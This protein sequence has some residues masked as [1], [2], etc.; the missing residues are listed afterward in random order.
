MVTFLLST[1]SPR[2][3]SSSRRR[4]CKEYGAKKLTSFAQQRP[5]L[6]RRRRRRL[7]QSPRLV[8]LSVARDELCESLWLCQY[9]RLFLF[10]FSLNPPLG[11][12][13]AYLVELCVFHVGQMLLDEQTGLNSRRRR[14][15]LLGCS[16]VWENNLA[17]LLQ[18]LLLRG[19]QAVTEYLGILT[20]PPRGRKRQ[21]VMERGTERL[22]SVYP[23]S[24]SI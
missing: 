4:R 9:C 8:A 19:G 14:G 21:Y 5:G 1:N 10:F 3:V 11:N 6:S 20:A 12:L 7:R 2:N 18:R 16:A 23:S 17:G 22:P 13:S 24:S 15:S